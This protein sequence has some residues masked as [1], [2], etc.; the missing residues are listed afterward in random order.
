MC[1]ITS[2]YSLSMTAQA[3]EAEVSAMNAAQAH[4]GP[5]G[6]HWASVGAVTLG[7]NH[8]KIMD[9]S[10]DSNQPYRF[11]QLSMVFNGEVYNYLELRRE[12]QQLGYSFET[13]SDTEVI[14]KSYHCW[15]EASVAR[16]VGMWAL[17]IWDDRKSQLFCSRDR[18]GIKPL[19]YQKQ[20]DGTLSFDQL[21][22]LDSKK[23]AKLMRDYQGGDLRQAKLVWKLCSLNYWLKNDF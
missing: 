8:L 13:S 11:E 18:F 12:L 3:R 21:D 20:P 23:I 6:S 10:E 1:G 15:G 5:D 4:R 14:L 2:V 7:H 9:L 17:A 19:V 22:W 16:F